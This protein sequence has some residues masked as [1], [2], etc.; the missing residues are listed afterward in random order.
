M[1]PE[2]IPGMSA[3]IE[4]MVTQ[5]ATGVVGLMFGAE[6]LANELRAMTDHYVKMVRPAGSI[7]NPAEREVRVVAARRMLSEF[8]VAKAYFDNEIATEPFIAAAIRQR[9][10]A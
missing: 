9:K 5:M 4:A 3:D 2:D 6:E 10:G 7:D 1:K 8:A